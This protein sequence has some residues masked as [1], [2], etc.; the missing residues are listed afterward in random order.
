LTVD[1]TVAGQLKFTIKYNFSLLK[2]IPVS[3]IKPVISYTV[4]LLAI[5]SP[6][7]TITTTAAAAAVP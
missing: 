7:T 4:G 5:L 6:T 3:E 2:N 1:A